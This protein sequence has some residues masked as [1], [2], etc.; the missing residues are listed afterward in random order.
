M[1]V[2]DVLY[3]E[4]PWVRMVK[5]NMDG[6]LTTQIN[7]LANKVDF[8]EAVKATPNFIPPASSTTDTK[9]H[10]MTIANG[11]KLSKLSSAKNYNAKD[12][13]VISATSGSTYES[14]DFTVMADSAGYAG[15][16][17]NFR[18][19]TP[20]FVSCESGKLPS[21]G[22]PYEYL[23]LFGNISALTVNPSAGPNTYDFTVTGTTFGT[24]DEY[25]VKEQSPPTPDVVVASYNAKGTGA[26]NT[27]T[28]LNDG[29]V[30]TVPDLTSGEWTTLGNGKIARKS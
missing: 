11:N 26:G 18:A 25:T 17:A 28:V 22:L 19:G 2:I 16:V 1:A 15:L 24:G 7:S 5:C 12:S 30:R 20:I 23:Y 21:T 14:I 4:S 6:T 27:V 13:T 8:L 29:A 10:E 9:Y 3:G